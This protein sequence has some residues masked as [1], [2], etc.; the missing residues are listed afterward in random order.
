MFLRQ[1]PGNAIR[2]GVSVIAPDQNSYA[3]RIHELPAPEIVQFDR[4][5]AGVRYIPDRNAAKVVEHRRHERL[6]RTFRASR[7]CPRIWQRLIEFAPCDR[8][9][10]RQRKTIPPC[11]TGTSQFFSLN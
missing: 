6:D 5:A 2:K 3:I 9:R 8:V 11:V 7:Q 4:K 10:A 1:R